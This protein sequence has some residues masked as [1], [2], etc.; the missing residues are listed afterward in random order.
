M[1]SAKSLPCILCFLFLLFASTGC[2]S[3]AIR[4][5]GLD[6][7]QN[8]DP[9]DSG[10][11]VQMPVETGYMP[12][13][14]L[15]TLDGQDFNTIDQKGRVL[16]INFWATWC[17]PCRVEIP[18][19]IALQEELGSEAF[20]VVGISVDQGDP[21]EVKEYVQS[22]NINYPILID[23]GEV[24]DA[25]GGVYALPTTFVI[26]KTGKITHKTIGIFPIEKAQEELAE[27]IASE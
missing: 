14:S 6:N 9:S 4:T 11:G 25:F 22:M 21:Q 7:T 20:D 12:D 5:N 16:L 27:M 15:T 10:A 23:D 17:A 24:A 3:A 19:L 1:T 26:D 18:D 13:F 8:S 2:E